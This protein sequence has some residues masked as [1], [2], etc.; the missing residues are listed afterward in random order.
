MKN[1]NRFLAYF[2]VIILLLSTITNFTASAATYGN[3]TYTIVNDEVAITRCDMFATGSVHI[4]SEIDGYPV[5]CIYVGA[6]TNC[7]KVTRI[8][9]PST[10]VKIESGAF[11]WISN[12]QGIYVDEENKNFCSENGILFNKDKTILLRAPRTLTE[13]EIPNSVTQIG[14]GAFNGCKNLSNV[15]IG[16]KVTSIGSSAFYECSN[17]VSI[18]IPNSVKTIEGSAFYRCTNLSNVEFGNSVTTIGDYA[19]NYCY[20]LTDISLPD[21]VTDINRAFNQCTGLTS[22]DIG[23]GVKSLDYR[24]FWDCSKLS[25]ITI[26]SSFTRVGS[27]AFEGCESLVNVY[28]YGTEAQW[29][30]VT[31]SDG[32][33]YLTERATMHYVELQRFTV[34]GLINSFLLDDEIKIELLVDGEVQYSTVDVGSNVRYAI[35]D[36]V[37][38]TYLLRICKENHVTHEYEIVVGETDVEI[39]AKICPVGDVTGDGNVNIKDFQRLLRHVNKTNP[40]EGYELLCGDVTGEGVC[41]IKDFQRLLRHVNKTS[42]LF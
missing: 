18:I 10:V 29:E 9:I 14:S 3:L 41:N 23:N 40:L 13:Y 24:A 28:Y 11:S 19:F 36:V 4:P 6:F 26:G 25:C 20:A 35:E 33:F 16:D 15:I 42:P 31:I 32:N 21:S 38:G 27:S 1:V 12:L 17:L 30:K 8:Y 37:P 2:I 22:I 7:T 5:T 39:D 34:S